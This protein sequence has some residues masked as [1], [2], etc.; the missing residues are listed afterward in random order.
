MK[1]II[2]LS[3]AAVVTIGLY[4]FLSKEKATT[5]TTDQYKVIKVDGQIVFQKTNVDMKSGD[6][7]MQG[8]ALNFKTPQSRAAVISN[9]KG[10]FVLSPSEQGTNILPAANNVSS[11]AGALLNLIDLQNHFAGKYLVLG[12]MKLQIGKEA[13]PMND[14]NF[15]YLSY[16]HNE[17]QIR[18]KL[19]FEGD[20]LILNKEEI[21]KIDGKS[22]PVEEKEMTLFYR[23]GKES[24]KISSFTPVFPDLTSLKSELEVI[25]EEYKEKD[26][27]TQIK[28]ITAYLNEFYGNPQKDNL[29]SW[30]STE[31]GLN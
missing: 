4:S 10:R 15:F 17:E 7:F 1:K 16:M 20:F 21:F 25:L 14:E 29:A 5:N 8:T 26:A 11:R 31:F 23:Q 12:E 3:A 22:I 9:L 2:L 24:K 18:K 28:E 27:A 6:V 19:E 13:F 30:L